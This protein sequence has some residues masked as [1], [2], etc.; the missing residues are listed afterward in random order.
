MHEFIDHIRS[1][2]W[3]ALATAW[4]SRI[5]LAVAVFA[6]GRLLAKLFGKLIERIATRAKFDVAL[7]RFL[8][9]LTVIAL[10]V[11]AAI[12]AVDQLGVD[13]TSLIAVL[14][15]AGL[16]I[17]LALKDSLANFA[18]SV[19]I[20]TFKPFKTGDFVE[21]GG[22]SGTV[23]DIGMFNTRMLTADNQYV[24]IPNSS[25][26]SDK[27]INYSREPLRR[28]SFEIGIGYN[29]DI[30]AARNAIL[31][32][33]A[34]DERIK[35]DPA[36]IVHVWAFGE[37]SV[38]LMMRIWTD[39]AIF[40]DVRSDLLERIKASFDAKGISI[41]FPQREIHYYKETE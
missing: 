19:M 10:T 33:V 16:A 7:V 21:A 34:S 3:A 28:L 37:S 23:V 30:D 41:P 9:S 38:N 22:A 27:T 35:T 12:F 8:T 4:G 11:I 26:T 6:I 18:S 36:P 20:M 29:D 13:T 5:L 32:V 15:A 39:T 1:L 40:W 17:G 25:I 31:E 2:D 14:G 24:V